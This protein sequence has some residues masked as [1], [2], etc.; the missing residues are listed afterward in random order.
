MSIKSVINDTAS[1]ESFIN[2]QKPL[3]PTISGYS[4]GGLDDTALDPAG[5]QTVQINGTGFLPGATL[6]FDGSAIAVVTY[7]NPNRLTF[8]SPAKSAGT[9]TIY[10]V[11]PD[12]G[13]AIYIPGIIYSVL[14]TWTTSAGSLG[15]VY[16]TNNISTSV[17]ASGD[18]P[19][20][21]SLYS[22]SLPSG[23]TLYANGVI[24]GT[25]PVDNSSTTYSFT[26]EAIDAELQGSTRSFSLTINTDV[27]TWVSPANA[28][29]YTSSV[30]S[31]I[32]NIT[33][34]ATDAAGYAITYS[35]NALPTGLSLS[36]ANI[37][38]T[39]TVVADSST[40]LTATAATTNRTATRTINWS[41]TVANDPYFEYVTVLIPGASTTFVDD[42]STNN[43]A[44]TPAGDTKPNNNNPYTPGYYS[45]YFDGTGDYLQKVSPPTYLCDWTTT[46][47]TIEYWIYAAAFGSGANGGSNVLG[48][49]ND[50]GDGE[51]WSFGTISTGAVRFYYYN[52]SPNSFT[53][54]TTLSANK[55]YH[56]AFVNNGGSLTIYIDGVSS[57]TSTKAGTP[58]FGSA[59]AFS[60][61][62][63]TGSSFNGYISNLRIV[64]SAVYTSN[65]TPTTSP[66][67]AISGTQ[68]LTCQSN[69]IIDNSTN[70]VVFTVYGDT[71]VKSFDPF[72]P[73]SNYSSYGSAYFDGTG[74]YLT[75]A[76]NTAFAFG[77][78]SFTIE[79]WI[80]APSNNDKFILGGRSAIG[81]MHITTGG[82]LSTAGV[83]RYVGSSTIV[84]SSVIT[85]NKWHHC[86]IVRDGSNNITLYVDGVSS[87]TGTDTTN[88]TTTTGTWVM[89]AN[90]T[91]YPAN[92]GSNN[93]TGYISNF[94]IVKGTAVYTSS[95][96]PPTTSLTAISGTSILTFQNNQSINNNVFLDNST[97]NFLVT[98]TGNTN[99]GTFSP[100]GAGYSVYLNNASYMNSVST[101]GAYASIPNTTNFDLGSGDFTM[102]GWIYPMQLPSSDDWPSNW[103][104]HSSLFGRG[105]P[106]GGDGYN[107][108][109]GATKLIF[110][111][112][113]SLVASGT[114]NISIGNWY[115]VAVSRVSSTLK[116]FVNGVSVASV[117]YNS[118]PGGGTYFYIGCETGQGAYF[119]GYMSNVRLVKG[120][121]LYSSTFTPSST[122]LQAVAGTQ[123]LTNQSQLF[124]DNSP[125]NYVVTAT[126]TP[127]IQRFNPF[128]GSTLPTPYYSAYFDGTG[129][130]LTVPANSAFNFGT[131]DFTVEMW[132]N[133]SSV[134]SV[135]TLITVYQNSS[136]GWGL[137]WR[138]D[139]SR[140]NWFFG[141]TLLMSYSMVPTVGTWAHVAVTRSGTSLRMFINGTVVVGPTTNSTTFDSSQ[142]LSIGSLYYALGPSYIQNYNGYLSNVRIVKGTAVYTSDFTPPTSPLTAISGTSLL[143]CQSNTFVDNSTNNFTI[144]AIGNS[145]PT[146]YNPFTLTYSTNQ[147]YSQSV[148]GGSMYFDGSG[149]YLTTSNTALAMGTGSFTWEAWVYWTGGSGS[150][151]QIF[152]TRV[153][154]TAVAAQGSLA[155]TPGNALIWF[156]DS[157]II[158]TTATL[159][160][161]SWNHVALVRNGTAMAVY[162]NGSSSG[163]ATNS[164]NLTA[165]VFSIGANNDGSEPFYG[166]ITDVRVI[167]NQ[168]IYLSNF[169]P[170]NY[171]LTAVQNSIYLVNGSSAGIYD[172]AMMNDFETLGD[173]KLSTSVSKFGGSSIYFDGNGDYLSGTPIGSGDLGTVDFT[174]EYWMNASAAGTYSGPVGTQ[175]VSGFAT[176]GMWRCLNRFNSSNGIYFAY[177]TGSAFVDITFTSTSYNDGNWHHIAYVKSGTS[178]KAYV[179]GTQVGTAATVTQSLSSGKKLTLGY[180]PQDSAYYAGYIDDLRITKGYARYT[181]NF[182]PPIIPFP[183]Y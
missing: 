7:V 39:P 1:S 162:I 44:V 140:M 115:H 5:G 79:F 65:F 116:L 17:V 158:T 74:D 174:I 103:W 52:G 53:T 128:N 87:G 100:Y 82:Y 161:Y 25:A 41:I 102:E 31:A 8:T 175:E 99:Q 43:F 59:I 138:N 120:T 183:I 163:T 105:T 122:P 48:N 124:V 98:R 169:T 95:F 62:T 97:N 2:A 66:L 152:S 37:S 42:A 60:I 61:G 15:S 150:Y 126:N 178:L 50:A 35:A 109:L 28:T 91:S 113:D 168:A 77:T 123:L 30:D 80:Y 181:S 147:P 16:E 70:N 121:G 51:Y 166:Y 132:Y 119:Y 69:R 40:L 145:K 89:G 108:I 4:V 75:F 180:N 67:T 170:L 54:S 56:L 47:F 118:S 13:T 141:D 55:W 167:K 157:S 14:P 92:V 83:L 90:D 10:V 73:N 117:S 156:T 27:V 135:Q 38:G 18:A 23:A 148:I 151:R 11:N 139:T 164:N 171:P 78:G 88:Y 19:I 63:C 143:T 112:N 134:S 182:T 159:Q 36:G 21:Y 49:V 131:G 46:N 6:T 130:Y 153:A 72:L 165:S 104:Q 29:T 9:Y 173:A 20:T 106:N 142:G 176:A 160:Q 144:T 125:N 86:A 71:S 32:A 101:A 107:L 94:R 64:Q 137:Q 26:I 33:L 110:Q 127:S 76:N 3:P 146:T 84:S 96:T 34:S 129:D 45:N 149:D 68:L 179:D 155:L 58:Q 133:F 22:G 24:S 177:T 114:H 111:S 136:N 81:T 85:D 93:L 57:A 12:G 154:S 172:A